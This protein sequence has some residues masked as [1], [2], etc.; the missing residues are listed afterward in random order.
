MT[1]SDTT[2]NRTTELKTLSKLK[3]A[4]NVQSRIKMA[5]TWNLTPI[6]GVANGRRAANENHQLA[7]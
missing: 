1:D 6:A 5:M 3:M 7:T 4:G 2:D